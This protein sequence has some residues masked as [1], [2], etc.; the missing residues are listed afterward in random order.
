[1]KITT[2]SI[3]AGSLACQAKCPFC[4][5][6]MTPSNNMTNKLPAVNWRNFRKA[7]LLAQSGGASTVLITSKGEPT[8]FPE[9]VTQYLEQLWSFNFPIIEMQTNGI[10]IV[11]GKVT[12]EQLQKWYELGLTTVAISIVH[13]D[14]AKNHEIY[15][16]HRKRKAAPQLSAACTPGATNG[17]AKPAGTLIDLPVLNGPAAE[18][19]S[20]GAQLTARAAEGEAAGYIDLPKLF[21]LL[22]KPERR[23]SI[24]LTCIAADGYIDSGAELEKLLAFAAAN[25]VEQV[26]LTPVTKPFD[27]EDKEAFDWVSKNFLKPDQL[28]NIKEFLAKNGKIVRPMP[29][30]AVVYDVGGQNLNLSNCLTRDL[31]PDEVRSL[32]FFPDGHVRTNWDLAGSLLF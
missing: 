30:G 6:R 2:L 10:A 26:T 15:L 22:Q 11:E 23:F 12:E 27:A 14:P 17:E 28:A 29:H 25:Q 21:K 13:Y 1:M 31:Q 4:V 18:T 24:R 19:T 8:L 16:P 9:Q 32:I 3:V 20:L 7:C 5:A